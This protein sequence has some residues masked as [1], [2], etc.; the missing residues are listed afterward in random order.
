M[1]KGAFLRGP[2]ECITG[3]YLGY[4]LCFGDVENVSVVVETDPEFIAKHLPAPMKP[5]DDPYIVVSCLN[6]GHMYEGGTPEN[7]YKDKH[8]WP[9]FNEQCLMIPATVGDIRGYFYLGLHMNSDV[10]T[11]CGRDT[12]GYPKKMGNIKHYFDPE[13]ENFV[14][15]EERCGIPF[16]DLHC[17][18]DGTPNE[19]D[20]LEVFERIAPSHPRFPD[21][22]VNLTVKW[23]NGKHDIGRGKPGNLFAHKP[24]ICIGTDT[25][26]TLSPS[27][28]GSADLKFTWSDQDPWASIPI[29]RV[30]GAT[31]DHYEYAMIGDV[32][33]VDIEDEKAFEKQAFY[34]SD[35]GFGHVFRF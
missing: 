23:A 4:D 33:Y 6:I 24:Y 1:K 11:C 18:F 17:K 2:E 21:R 15:W 19:S 32:E 22:G 27:K 14:G 3:W 16:F 26:E 31:Y 5:L 34:G 7:D 9:G 13:R 28:V 25:C 8:E 10:A 35:Y 29:K 20:F 30:L 12:L